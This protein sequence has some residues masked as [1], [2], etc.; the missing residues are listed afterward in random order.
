MYFQLEVDYN[1]NEATKNKCANFQL[2]ASI[3]N[4]EKK[5]EDKIV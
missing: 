3:K 4:N 1:Y 2:K 5:A